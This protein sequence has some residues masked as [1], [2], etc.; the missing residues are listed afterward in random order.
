MPAEARPAGVPVKTQGLQ[1]LGREQGISILAALALAD[2]DAHAVWRGLDV[3]Y[4]EGAD[5]GH[6]QAS[7]V[8]GHQ[9]GASA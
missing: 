5:F 8:G 7:G 6:A 2:L 4:L 1:Q 9:H 3:A